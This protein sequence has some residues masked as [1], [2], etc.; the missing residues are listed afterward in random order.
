[1]KKIYFL[2]L[3]FI[4]SQKLIAQQNYC[5]FEGN[6]VSSFG[7]CTGLLDSLSLNPAP[8]NIDSSSH[9]A[10]YVRDTALYDNIKLYTTLK[11]EDVSAYENSSTQAP[12]I[13]MKIYSNAPIGTSVHLQLGIR[14]VDNYPAGIHSEFGAITTVQNAWE[15]M[16]FDYLESP[17]GS[18]ATA[19]TIDKIVLL[20]NPN[21]TA[22][23][24][25]YFDDLTGPSLFSA[26]GVS[27]NETFPPLKLSQNIPNPAKQS[28]N[29]G[30]Q[31]NS[32]GLVT[33]ELYDVLGNSISTM[34]HQEM[35]AGSYSIPLETSII[36]N[37]IYFYVLKKDGFSLTRRLV[38]SK[39]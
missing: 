18:L 11:L 12:K 25:V 26:T 9:C 5:D 32:P 6:S 15:L 34:V 36:P 16:T 8:N 27:M 3:I 38:V 39:N 22:R 1:M 10:R 23:D 31:L 33:L 14:S 28:T 2:I 7:I 24:T 37:G 4:V 29:I 21:S 20:F 19:T 17:A 30:F 35:K 13:Q